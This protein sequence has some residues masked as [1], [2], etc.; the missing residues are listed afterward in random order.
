MDSQVRTD[1]TDIDA[2][3]NGTFAK[4]GESPSVLEASAKLQAMI[5]AARGAPKGVIDPRSLPVRF[6]RLKAFSLSA[7][8]Y[9]LW[10]QDMTEETIALRMGSAVHAGI[11]LNRKIVCYDGRRTGKAWERFERHH[12]ELGAIILNEKEYRIAVGIVDAVRRH[13]RAMDLLFDGTVVEERIDWKFGDRA[14]RG[15]PD[16]YCRTRN[17]DLKSARSTEPRWFAREAIK[18]HYHAQM[19]SYDD[20]IAFKLGAP[21][22][23]DY[24]VAVENVA[25]FNVTVLRLPDKTREVGAKLCRQWWEQLLAAESANY[26]GGYCESDIELEIPEYDDH[27]GPTQVEVDGRLITID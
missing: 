10:C 27:H 11:F 12:Q 19:S 4:V 3:L 26:Y 17:T 7:A 6:S 20:A 2:M 21:P 9:L 16:A 15:T 18:R 5:D 8:H 14:C 13:E 25:P 22:V 24:L 1:D 23:E